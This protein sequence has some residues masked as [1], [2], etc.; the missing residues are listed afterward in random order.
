MSVCRLLLTEDNRLLV[1]ACVE[2]FSKSWK[3]CG[4]TSSMYRKTCSKSNSL[5]KKKMSESNEKNR[6]NFEYL[7]NTS[8]SSI[9]TNT[10]L[11]VDKTSVYCRIKM[12]TIDFCSVKRLSRCD[13]VIVKACVKERKR[14]S[15]KHVYI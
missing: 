7:G 1:Q 10:L 4:C 2:Q 13:V 3:T 12:L 6:E 8:S 5:N 11:D 9:D 14:D 15:N